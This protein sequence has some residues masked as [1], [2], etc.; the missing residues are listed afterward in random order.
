MLADAAEAAVR[1]SS[2]QSPPDVD[3]VLERIFQ[4]RLG[5]GQLDDSDLTLRDLQRVRQAFVAV[6]RRMYH[7]RIQYPAGIEPA[8]ARPER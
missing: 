3:G 1:A 7:P 8:P 5:S 6:F 2:L 4:H